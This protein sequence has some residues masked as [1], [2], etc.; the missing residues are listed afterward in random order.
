ML[1][2]K[3]PVVHSVHDFKLVLNMDNP[4]LHI[5]LDEWALRERTSFKCH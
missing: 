5:D 2:K 3:L 4:E 1:K